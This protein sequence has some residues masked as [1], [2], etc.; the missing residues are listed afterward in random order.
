MRFRCATSGR[1]REGG[2]SAATGVASVARSSHHHYVLL[3][4]GSS[5]TTTERPG[6]LSSEIRIVGP[7]GPVALSRG[8]RLR[9]DLRVRNIGD[10]CWLHR[11]VGDSHAGWTRLGVHLHEAG[12]PVGKVIDFDWHRAEFDGDVEPESGVRMRY[13]LP[14]IHRPGA[15]D[16]RFDL[17]VEGLTWFAER[18]ASRAAS[19]AG[20][21]LVAGQLPRRF[22]VMTE[23]CSLY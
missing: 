4:K 12:E 6:K 13:D 5:R 16:L 8:E 21:R 2:D 10:T 1:S 11:G 3:Y 9:V 19:A 20:R 14:P 15:Y 17:V 18:G 7:A 23:G 22:E